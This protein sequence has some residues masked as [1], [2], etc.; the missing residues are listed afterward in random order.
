MWGE[1]ENARF[2]VDKFL[3]DLSSLRK[4]SRYS[5]LDM[6]QEKEYSGTANDYTYYDN[7]YNSDPNFRF[8]DKPR[9]KLVA[10][11]Y[12]GYWDINNDGIVKPIVATWVGDTMIRLEENP[13]PDKQIPF[14]VV[15][16]L[17]PDNETVYG[18][19]DA[20]TIKR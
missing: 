8:Q 15:Q 7:E 12:W 4:D 5:N 11:E 16:Y 3:T 2:I 17:P 18:D 9:Q 13:Y 10:Y 19:A 6:I 14:V 20:S 1:I